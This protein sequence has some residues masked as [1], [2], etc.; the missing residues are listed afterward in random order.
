MRTKI[1]LLIVAVFLL[2]M[3]HSA[4]AQ[5][6]SSWYNYNVY[7]GGG[8]YYNYLVSNG[9]E[10]V[11]VYKSASY[12]AAYYSYSYSGPYGSYSWYR[13]T[14]YPVYY[15]PMYYHYPTYPGLYQSRVQYPIRLR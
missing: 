8:G 7:P 14:S 12:G 1:G 3:S 10:T 15:R 11:S 6:P 2:V 13:N 4:Y 5:Y 9:Y